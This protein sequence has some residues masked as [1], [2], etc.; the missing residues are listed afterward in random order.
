MWGNPVKI[1]WLFLL[2]RFNVFLTSKTEIQSFLHFSVPYIYSLRSQT[3]WHKPSKDKE[4]CITSPSDKL[5]QMKT[6]IK[7][8]NEHLWFTCKWIWN[9]VAHLHR[10]PQWLT[11]YLLDDGRFF[12]RSAEI[13]PADDIVMQWWQ[14]IFTWYFLAKVATFWVGVCWSQ[15]C[16]T[17]SQGLS[18]AS[19][20]NALSHASI[21]LYGCRSV[22]ECCDRVQTFNWW[23]I[24][25]H[26]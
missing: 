10:P 17:A 21:S 4:E 1:H 26:G 25:Y 19:L 5:W 14:N 9:L 20:S 15:R 18:V 11:A 13:N 23:S 7:T 8:A 3:L 22:A 16:F 12:R 6:W 24:M 2:E